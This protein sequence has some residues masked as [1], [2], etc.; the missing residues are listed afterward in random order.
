M[1]CP[2][3]IPVYMDLAN[4]LKSSNVSEHKE[5]LLLRY[6]R[7]GN[8]LQIIRNT[9]FPIGIQDLAGHFGSE[10][11]EKGDLCEL[12]RMKQSTCQMEMCLPMTAIVRKPFIEL[13][14]PIL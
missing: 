11:L 1:S 6:I 5:I 10:G 8:M 12:L 14:L 13:T 3:Q 4:I 9:P 7:V 2:N